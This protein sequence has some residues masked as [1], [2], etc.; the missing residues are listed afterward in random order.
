VHH[1]GTNIDTPARCPNTAFLESYVCKDAI[2]VLVNS[3]K[4]LGF[5]P[6]V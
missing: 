5:K 2:Q 1:P 3:I 6:E 4:R